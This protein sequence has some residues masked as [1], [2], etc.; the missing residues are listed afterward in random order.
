MNFSLSKYEHIFSC[1]CGEG[2]RMNSY[3]MDCDD[4][5]ECS[6]DVGCLGDLNFLQNLRHPR[7]KFASR[8]SVV[9]TRRVRTD[10][11]AGK[12]INK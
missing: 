2:Y 5:D 8:L 7:L 3:G 1:R 11:V 6:L 10:A 9:K 4:I 12:V